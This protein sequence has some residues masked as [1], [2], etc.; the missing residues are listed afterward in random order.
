MHGTRRALSAVPLGQHIHD[1]GVGQWNGYSR[2]SEFVYC[3][4][5]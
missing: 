1:E 3:M 4:V 2:D 5:D